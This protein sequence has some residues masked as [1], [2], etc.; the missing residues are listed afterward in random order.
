[1]LWLLRATNPLPTHKTPA[2][3][4][5]GIGHTRWATHGKPEE[6]NAHPHLDGP[7]RVAVVQNVIIENDRTLREELQ[8][9]GV[10]FRILAS[11]SA[12]ARNESGLDLSQPQEEKAGTRYWSS[13]CPS[14]ADP[15][16]VFMGCSPDYRAAQPAPSTV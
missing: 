3:L 10:V 13:Y 15:I 12:N 4:M 7:G 14:S 11:G 2:T 16:S 9:E 1:M 8:A 5:C 6:R